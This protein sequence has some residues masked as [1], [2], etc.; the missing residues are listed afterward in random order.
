[1]KLKHTL[2]AIFITAI[3]GLNFSVIKLGLESVD[4]YILAGIRFFLCAIPAVF[5]IKKPA[6]DIKYLIVYGLL[7]GVGLWGIVNLGIQAGLSAGIAALFY[8]LV[9]FLLLF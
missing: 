8:N 3:W 6:I 4:P 2:L 7:F 1:M 5:F 9:L